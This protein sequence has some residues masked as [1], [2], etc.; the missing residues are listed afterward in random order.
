MFLTSPLIDQAISL[1][2][3]GQAAGAI[4]ARM[5]KVVHRVSGAARQVG[6]HH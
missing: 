6:A 3:P 2:T 5:D 4:L 1:K